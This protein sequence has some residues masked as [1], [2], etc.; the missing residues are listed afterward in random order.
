MR[1]ARKEGR[2]KGETIRHVVI[3]E[4]PLS[5]EDGGKQQC[6][7]VKKGSSIS[8]WKKEVDFRRRSKKANHH[9]LA[10]VVVVVTLP[11]F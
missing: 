10:V 5:T 7:T 6:S 9:T 3:T 4:F 8:T 1:E 11:S 2:K